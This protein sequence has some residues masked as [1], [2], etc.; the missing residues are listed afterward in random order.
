[1]FKLL[2]INNPFPENQNKVIHYAEL[3]D[4]YVVNIASGKIFKKEILEKALEENFQ[5]TGKFVKF[6]HC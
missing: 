1:M 3:M 5:D 4:G 2:T 6:Q